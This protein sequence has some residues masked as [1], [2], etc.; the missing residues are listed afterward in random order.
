METLL[1]SAQLN[2]GPAIYL[3]LYYDYRRNGADMQ[4]RF[5]YKFWVES[6]G[7]Y[8]N[9][10]RMKFYLN[11]SNVYTRNCQSYNSAWSYEYTT[12][13][14][15]VS[16]KTSGTTPFYVTINDTQNDQ[17]LQYSSGTWGLYVAPAYTSISKFNVSKISGYNGLTQVKVDWATANNC[18]YIWYSTNNGSDWTSK[19]VNSSSGSFN[20]SGLSPGTSYKFKLRVR[21]SDSQLTTDSGSVTQSTYP[22][23][24]ISSDVPN[25]SNGD[26]LSVTATNPSGASCRIRLETIINGETVSRFTKT[27]TSAKFTVEE[28]NSLLEYCTTSSTFTIRI[29]ADTMNGDTIGYKSWKDATYKIIGSEPTFSNFTF[30]DISSVTD[31]TGDNQVL[32]KN[33]SVLKVII[34]ADNKMVAKNNATPNRYD[35]NCANRSA[36]VNYADTEVSAELGT[37]ANTGIIS[38]NVKAVDSRNLTTLVTKQ[39]EVVDYFTP[40]MVY[41]IGRVNNFENNTLIKLNGSFAKVVV[42]NEIKNTILSAKVRYKVADDTSD[43]GSWQNITFSVNSENGTYSCTDKTIL[44][45]NTETYFVQ[46]AIQDKFEEAIE[47]VKIAE[48]VPIM[49]ISSTYKNVGIGL[50]NSNEEYSLQVAGN[51]YFNSGNKMLDYD[52]VEDSDNVKTFKYK[53]NTYVDSSGVLHN[54]VTLNTYL[55]SM[56]NDMIHINYVD[57]V[58]VAT[59][60]YKNGKRVYAKKFVTTQSL[61]GG[62]TA[63]TFPH[64]ITGATD[65]W[66]DMGNSYFEPNN[67]SSLRCPLPVVAYYGNF[68]D[69]VYVQCDDTNLYFY[70][71]TGWGTNW[72]KIVLIKYTKD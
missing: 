55:E 48:G 70:H 30:Q 67:D 68:S 47:T 18:D 19:Y 26:S 14:Y 58:E 1:S 8:Q 35:I 41:S 7:Y 42:D 4:Y 44:L 17:W 53:D 15:T 45:D 28:L 3:S 22:I 51:Y 69:R 38:C 66:L 6:S 63:N 32:V 65:L 25:V 24:T 9:N 60:E 71:D 37:I 31:I 10:L 12:D 20:I 33:K 11:G 52:V 34:S 43:Y 50:Q 46:I 61:P 2:W 64:G 40:T 59:N 56:I 57:N 36:T 16:G 54:N 62:E 49:F 72:K 39:I 13:W 27:G 23:N 29:V 21:R 5:Y